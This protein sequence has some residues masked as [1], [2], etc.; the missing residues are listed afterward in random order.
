MIVLK[1]GG[2]AIT[3]KHGYMRPDAAGIARLASAVA[4][5]WRAGV[6]NVVLVHG[7]GS[8]GHAPVLRYGINNGVRSGKQ[9]LGYAITHSSVSRLSSLVADALLKKGVPAVSIPPAAIV[10]QENRRI[11]SFDSKIVLGYIK[12]GYLPVLYGDMVLDSRLGGSVCS[13][14]QI[15]AHLGRKASRMIFATNVDGVL[16]CGKTVPE[17]TKEN[18][19]EVKRHLLSSGAPDVTGGMAGKIAEI[20]SVKTPAYVV[21]AKKP[22][23]VVALL[24]GKKA[25]CTKIKL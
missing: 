3:K 17:I 19:A 2:S 25:I 10:R 13:G 24:L 7:A 4:R 23:R 22:E 16:A 12:A 11:A 9:R 21:N 5:A 18:F 6:R 15:A 1:L 14:D 20:L 8:F